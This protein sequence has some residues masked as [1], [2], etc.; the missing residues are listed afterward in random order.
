M[1]KFATVVLLAFSLGGCAQLQHLQEIISIGTASIANP[2]TKDRL[3]KVE[4]AAT[5]VFVGLNTWKNSCAQRLIN[6][7]C[8]AQIEAVQVYTRQ[9][10]PYLAQLRAFVKNNDQVNAVVVYN[11]ITKL[12]GTVKSQAAASNII[13]GG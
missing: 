8:Q 11:N 6:A 9:I 4:A 5:L 1:R 10:P 7:T 13:L 12:I 3:R 2:V